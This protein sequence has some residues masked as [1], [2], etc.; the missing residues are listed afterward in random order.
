MSDS[1]ILTCVSHS[2]TAVDH[3]ET[4]VGSLYELFYELADKGRLY[5]FSLVGWEDTV[6]AVL[7]GE[8]TVSAVLY[9]EDADITEDMVKSFA[10]HVWHV[11]VDDVQLSVWNDQ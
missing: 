1:Y 11:S 5:G 7:Y 2:G 4:H 3:S 6:S 10:A 9:G 8:D